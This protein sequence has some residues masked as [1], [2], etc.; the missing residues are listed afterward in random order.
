MKYYDSLVVFSH[1]Q[2]LPSLAKPLY[3]IGFKLG[4]SDQDEMTSN[5]QSYIEYLCALQK[6]VFDDKCTIDDKDINIWID[7]EGN[8]GKFSLKD[9]FFK[10]YI[11]DAYAKRPID[12]M[13]LYDCNMSFK[14]DEITENDFITKNIR[15]LWKRKY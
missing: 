14:D 8:A 12:Y 11:A 5:V 4:G 10:N 6:W 7:K 9:E 15:A 1:S 2:K 3:G 13:I